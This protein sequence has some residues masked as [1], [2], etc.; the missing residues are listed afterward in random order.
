MR[1]GE[2]ERMKYERTERRLKGEEGRDVRPKEWIGKS[3]WEGS[4][5]GE[6][7]WRGEGIVCGLRIG[8]I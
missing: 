8:W 3:E 2:R 6:V 7:E 1:T 4:L 5:E